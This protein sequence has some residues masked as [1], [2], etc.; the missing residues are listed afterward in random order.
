V[1][2]LALTEAVSIVA[3]WLVDFDEI[4]HTLKSSRQ[5]SAILLTTFACT[6]FLTPTF[7]PFRV[8]SQRASTLKG[9]K[10]TRATLRVVSR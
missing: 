1:T 6:L 3:W 9:I 2:L 4:F 5:E 10:G 7:M 8:L